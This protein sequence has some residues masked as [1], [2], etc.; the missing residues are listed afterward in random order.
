LVE[1]LDRTVASFEELKARNEE[2]QESE[3]SLKELCK[4]FEEENITLQDELDDS[5]Y[6]YVVITGRSCTKDS[7]VHLKIVVLSSPVGEAL[8]VISMLNFVGIYLSFY[9]A[10]LCCKN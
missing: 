7:A 9:V 2:L 3:D 4:E 8:F 10:Q 1:E 5:S 6:K